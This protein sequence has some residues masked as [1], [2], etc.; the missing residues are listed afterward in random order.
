MRTIQFAK[1]A[2]EAIQAHVAENIGTRPASSWT[3]HDVIDTGI[4]CRALA[5]NGL[6]NDD[7]TAAELEDVVSPLVFWQYYGTAVAEVSRMSPVK[8]ALAAL[9]AGG[10]EYALTDTMGTRS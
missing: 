3:D 7:S 4:L 10:V 2:L 6:P 9:A 1:A 8:E 5:D